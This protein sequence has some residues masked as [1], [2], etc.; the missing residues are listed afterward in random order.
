MLFWLFFSL[1][2]HFN[3]EFFILFTRMK[4]ERNSL[5]GEYVAPDKIENVY[6]F[7]PCVQQIF[8]DGDS[9]ER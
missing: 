9:L 3:F 5:Q 1:I 2:C 4:L 7:A 8:V 6:S